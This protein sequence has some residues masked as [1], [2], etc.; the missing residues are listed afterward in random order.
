MIK[1]TLGIVVLSVIASLCVCRT[2]DAQVLN[3]R[4]IRFN[5]PD[6]T[7]G[8]NA[9]TSYSVDFYAEG[10]TNP[11][12]SP[13]VAASA[14]TAVPGT[15]PQDYEITFA[16]LTSYPVGQ[17]LTVKIRPVN[18]AGSGDAS[19]AS[20]PFGRPGRP[21]PTSQPKPVP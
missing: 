17:L 21:A 6:H 4:A 8:L 11:I 14:V 3:P 18:L 19:P 9:P 13:S 10:A 2:A 15:T 12:Q 1:R 5:S 16:Q 7:S 20:V